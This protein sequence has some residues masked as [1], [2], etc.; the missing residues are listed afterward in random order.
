LGVTVA[1]ANI[2]D[3]DPNKQFKDRMVN[4]Q[5]SQADLSL[6]RLDRAKEEEQKRL[7][8]ARGEREVEEKRQN[9]LK[10]QVEFTTAAETKRQLAVIDAGREKERAEIEKQTAAISYDKAIIEARTTKELADAEAYAKKALIT[11]DGALKQKLDAWV[12]TNKAWA[13]AASKAP[14]PGI[15]M[16][17]AGSSGGGAGSRQADLNDYMQIIAAKSLKDLSLDLAVKQ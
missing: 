1:E 5:K 17:A 8:T 9:A 12:E 16:G 10:E 6:A 14:V 4:A 3:I 11:A 15:M 7:V 13:D 2:L